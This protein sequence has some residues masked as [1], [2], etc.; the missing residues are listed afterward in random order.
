[1][2]SLSQNPIQSYKEVCGICTKFIRIGQPSLNCHKCDK[3]FHKVCHRK[4][5]YLKPFREKFYCK[6]CIDCHDIIRYNPFFDLT[7]VTK[8]DD[9]PYN[10]NEPVEYLQS[11]QEI[12]D[13]LENCKN[14]NR[15]ELS[16]HY[17][18]LVSEKLQ[19]F[20]T[21][22]H[23]IDGN[24]ANFDT[25]CAHMN[26]LDTEFSIVGIA[27]TNIDNS[28]KDLYKLSGNYSSVYLSKLE[29]K[30]KGSGLGLY[31]NNR[32][33]FTVA[34][35][36]CYN[37]EHLQ[38]LFIS[39]KNMDEPVTVGVL[40][41][42]PNGNISQFNSEMTDIISKIGDSMCYILGD[43]NIDMF[44]LPSSQTKEFEEVIISNGYI[45]TIS[46]ATHHQE[47]C[48]KTCIDNIFTNNKHPINIVCSG[49][50]S[51]YVSAHRGIFQISSILGKSHVPTNRKIKVEYEYSRE[52]IGR[53]VCLLRES[54]VDNVPNTMESLVSIVSSCIDSTCRLLKPKTT[55]RNPICNPWINQC[56]IESISDN[57]RLYESWVSTKKAGH[58]GDK[59]L[60][61]KLKA[62]QKKLRWLIKKAKSEYYL[63][64]FNNSN[65]DRK[66]AWKLINTLRGHTKKSIKPSFIISGERIICRRIIASKF[67]E[68]FVNMAKNLNKEA[69]SETPLSEYPTFYS[70]LNKSPEGSMM[71]E[72]C[73]EEE[74]RILIKELEVGKSSDIPIM[75]IKAAKEELV[76]LL[77]NIY[78]NCMIE[79]IFPQVLK[80]S[81]VTP[82]FKKGNME[83]LENY[84]PVSTLPIFGKIF[85]KIIYKR[86][87]SFLES[88]GILNDGQF[89]FRKNH[90]TGHAIHHSVNI[91][92]EALN[93]GHEVLGIF[94][95]LSKAFDTI[96]H[97]ILLS[98]LEHYGVRGVPN[99]L[100]RSYL[101]GRT[102]Y[103]EV[104]GEKSKL[105]DIMYGVPQG[106][107]LGPLLFIIYINDIINCIGDILN[108]KLVLYADDTNVFIVGNNRKDLIS[109]G[110]IVLH[111]IN[112]FM[113]SNLLHINIGKC[114]YI[115]F[116][117]PGSESDINSDSRDELTI[118]GKVINEVN[119]TKF[120]GVTIDRHLTWQAHI[121]TLHKKLKS[122]TGILR[123]IRSNIPKE[124]YK[125]LYHT[126]F[127]SHLT[128][129]ITVFGNA[130]SHLMNK[131]FVTQKHCLR[132]LFG[133][134]EAYLEKF[135]TSC[136]T[137]P[138]ESQ[139]LD[140]KFYSRE[141]TKPLFKDKD[142]M[143]VHNLYIYHICLET[144]KIIR[145]RSPNSLYSVITLSTRNS[146][147]LMIYT[148]DISNFTEQR[149]T[150]WNKCVNSIIKHIPIPFIKLSSFKFFIKRQI[151]SMQCSHDPIEW[152]S[153]L[154][155]GSVTLDCTNSI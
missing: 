42:P 117:S 86:F 127:E 93:R 66:K 78:N 95:D 108:V 123:R 68:M 29:N 122:A 144:L 45:P 71:L 54:I 52:R 56:I 100:L 23:N 37:S 41:R 67:Q 27:E 40:Y 137:R 139:R 119:S 70:Y 105:D 121:E 49:T 3:I 76:P 107:V 149:L 89:G 134:L 83:L 47:G 135:N 150:V 20:S 146:G 152:Y 30:S 22:F 87:I 112:K 103:T 141:H 35:D 74:I 46:V 98:K 38:S 2:I 53:F 92:K 69:Y 101:T 113:K 8:F 61:E 145:N 104:L 154:N 16:R 58:G 79:G 128:Y 111:A 72:D 63:S 44:T 99:S 129:C 80:K 11:I 64:K 118:N 94:I 136:R 88:K 25:F 60:K 131:L 4:C 143:T 142:I 13:I 50:V 114:C 140:Y 51:G 5:K 9:K 82:I 39:I 36:L 153:S 33:N 77:T 34:E 147:N 151:L 15:M 130:R 85:E 48:R 19:L 96:D 26:T 32:Y 133:N 115:H 124:C 21:Y 110:N 120:L 24:Q 116:C 90:S 7:V 59:K 55:K 125:T 109:T 18:Q 1:M 73:T 106:S 14:F 155:F 65:G 81:R 75:L 126:L 62:H 31:V 6:N 10:D 57:D 12:S 138:L 102:Q 28:H 97:R 148:K 43:I 17:N 132:I 91:V 84:R